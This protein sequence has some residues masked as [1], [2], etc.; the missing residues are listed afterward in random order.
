MKFTREAHEVYQQAYAM[1][2]RNQARARKQ[3]L[4]VCPAALNTLTDD[5]RISYHLDLGVMDIPTDLIVGVAEATEKS[6]LYSREFL[7]VS[8]PKSDF[9][10][11]WRELSRQ[12]FSGEGLPGYIRCFE[13]LGK[14][15]VADGLKRVS[16]AK[17]HK[18]H[19]IKAQVIRKMPIRTEEKS[20]QQYYEF[21]F[22]FRLTRLYQLQ[23]TQRGYFEKFQA[24]LG[25][26][27]TYKWTD[28]DRA[29]FL[30]IWPTIE[31][32]FHK[33][34]DEHLYITAADAMVV[35]LEKYTF[36]QIAH[37]DSWMLARIF[38]TF[39]KELYTLSFPDFKLGGKQCRSAETLQTA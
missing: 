1:A 32:A 34:Y 33:S 14:F 25:N 8:V 37:M 35:L 2:V 18:A 16:V 20:V 10:N 28:T 36:D 21:L 4:P 29:Q 19:V 22:H 26:E 15:Y 11:Q 23:F 17:F 27:P 31:Y 7:P 24:A 13:Y 12:Y 6:V 30:E 38:Q 9:A 39:W 5:G 3:E